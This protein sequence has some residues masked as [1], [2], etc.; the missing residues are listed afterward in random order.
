MAEELSS[1]KKDE[2]E[3]P[4]EV[5]EKKSIPKIAIVIV[6]TLI[7]MLLVT[8]LVGYFV[9][10]KPQPKPVDSFALGPLYS[11]DPFVVNLIDFNG[12]RYLKTEI[13]LE[14]ENEKMFPEVE[15]KI[16]FIRNIVINILSSKTFKDIS[17]VEGKDSLRREIVY[18]VN[19]ALTS[20]KVKNVFFK[21]FVVQ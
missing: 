7:V 9:T 11:L 18:R 12:R 4:E 10:H 8:V 3:Q 21:D 16:P 1:D 20:G 6:A 5:V 14:L 19:R 17:S 13:D 2:K 15:K